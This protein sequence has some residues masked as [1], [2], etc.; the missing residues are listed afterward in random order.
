MAIIWII[1][2]RRYKT[3]FESNKFAILFSNQILYY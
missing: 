2:E 3:G 1:I